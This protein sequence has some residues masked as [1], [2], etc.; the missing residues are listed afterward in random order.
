[1][2][3]SVPR[4]TALVQ[5]REDFSIFIERAIFAALLLVTLVV[6]PR[7]LDPFSL[8]KTLILISISTLLIPALFLIK[9]HFKGARVLVPLIAIG[10][11]LLSNLCSALLSQNPV[12]GFFGEYA[13]NNGFLTYLSLAILSTVAFKVDLSAHRTLYLIAILGVTTS[14]YGIIQYRGMDLVTWNNPFNPIITT[15]G[16][17]NFA[18][19]F[20][21]ITSAAVIYLFLI[22]K[23]LSQKIVWTFAFTLIFAAIWLSRVTQGLLTLLLCVGLFALFIFKNRGDRLFKFGLSIFLITGIIGALGIFQK[24][25][26]AAILGKTTFTY[27]LDYWYAAWQ[28]FREFPILGVGPDQYGNYFQEYRSLE[29]VQRF[30]PEV[31]ANNA[32]SIFM[33]ILATCGALGF[34]SITILIA[35]VLLLGIK[36]LTELKGDMLRVQ[37]ALLVTFSAYLLQASVSIDHVG[38]AIWGWISGALIIRTSLY[39][40]PNYSFDRLKIRKNESETSSIGKYYLAVTLSLSLFIPTSIWATMKFQTDVATNELRLP[41]INN[42]EESTEKFRQVIEKNAYDPQYLLVAAKVFYSEFGNNELSVVYANR[43]IKKEPRSYDAWNLIAVIREAEQNYTQALIY[44]A[45][46]LEL[47]PLN[48]EIIYRQAQNY[49]G[50]GNLIAYEELG[51]KALKLT[52]ATEQLYPLLNEL[53]NS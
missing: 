23:K 3:A 40:S 51:K 30:G 26:L 41:D 28:M 25:P 17:P 33:Q 8:P 21:G 11:F 27:R 48:F 6:T 24:G 22:S 12:N 39:S 50:I 19:A 1:M 53:F 14:I 16:N 7:A 10:V 37:L 34:I 52:P 44:R 2:E 46:T 4:M 13:R 49:K 18:A 43:A 29:Q 42:I 31:M 15:Y 38:L 35:W 5:K 36:S 45:K 9:T 47:D 32:H 20:F